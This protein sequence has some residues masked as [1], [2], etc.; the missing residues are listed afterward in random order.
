MRLIR[1]LVGA[2]ALAC[3]IF[4]TP[5][6]AS[7]AVFVG[8]EDHGDHW[9]LYVD[10]DDA[11]QDID[12]T[13]TTTSVTFTGGVMDS[14]TT[15]IDSLCTGTGPVTCTFL[16][17]DTVWISANLAGGDDVF[18]A[19]TAS[20]F[21]TYLTVVDGGAGNDHLIGTPWDDDITGGAGSDLV[22]G[23]AGLDAIYLDDGEADQ[24][25]SDCGLGG[26]LLVAD[27]FDP[28]VAN[29]EQRTDIGSPPPPPP[30][31]PSNVFSTSGFSGKA[32]TVSVP[33]PGTLTVGPA[34]KA[35]A[36]KKKKKKTALIASTKLT[37]PVAGTYKVPV[38]LTAEGK[39]QLKRKKIK[40]KVTVT[41]LP[42]GGTPSSQNATVVFK[43]AKKKKK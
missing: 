12:V 7:A 1:G 14:T 10:G 23:R 22:D 3:T 9:H 8:G 27:Y 30:S 5:A 43:K 38:K 25:G 19:S 21:E 40:A 34:T 36:S 42:N 32:L 18:D 39:R 35:S 11:V 41:F 6:L 4:A 37:A 26:D 17:G 24:A 20:A 16:A 31:P 2:C 29:C 28:V 13:N 33:G 15:D